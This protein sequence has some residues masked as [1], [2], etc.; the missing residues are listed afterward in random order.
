MP[1][2]PSAR[3][4][5][6]AF[7]QI[8]LETNEL[9]GRLEELQLIG[10]A[11]QDE[12]FA[13]LLAAPQVKLADKIRV[14]AEILSSVS[15]L[16]RNLVSLLA[17]R[18]MVSLVPGIL[19]HYM[20]FLDEHNGIERAEVLTAVP[21]ESQQGARV[22]QLLQDLVGKEVQI[23]SRVEP[24]ILGGMVAKV[25]DRIIDGSTK[26]RLQDMRKDLAEAAF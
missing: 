25:G 1:R 16:A 7:F 19:Q 6:Q 24:L 13:A 20:R 18:G 9:D 21:L 11:L 14:I 4:Y 8:A 22:V 2:A 15:P 5:A 3:R 26:T 17:S 10:Q 23:T 12:D